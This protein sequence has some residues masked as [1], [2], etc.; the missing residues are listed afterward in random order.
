MQHELHCEL[1]TVTCKRGCGFSGIP[2]ELEEHKPEC[3]FVVEE[4][5]RALERKTKQE[6]FSQMQSKRM[7]EDERLVAKA[8]ENC[9]AVLEMPVSEQ[10]TISVEVSSSLLSAL[11][12]YP[13]C[14]LNGQVVDEKQAVSFKCLDR[15]AFEVCMEWM[16]RYV[17]V[18]TVG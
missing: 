17:C 5:R 2:A 15:W 7:E 14:V 11:E 18:A 13:D 6:A 3:P 1:R 16:K 12:Q 9:A 10:H 4:N 8:K